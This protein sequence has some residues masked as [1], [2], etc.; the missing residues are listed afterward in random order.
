MTAFHPNRSIRQA[1]RQSRSMPRFYPS[2]RVQIHV[3]PIS[4]APTGSKNH[5]KGENAKASTTLNAKAANAAFFPR[6]LIAPFSRQRRICGPKWRCSSNRAS[7]A[8]LDRA[9]QKAAS[10]MNG[11]VGNSGRK[12]PIAPSPNDKNPQNR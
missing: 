8:G 7:S 11:T 9:K 4:A 10:I 1:S 12:A 2:G 3:P 5:G 6:R